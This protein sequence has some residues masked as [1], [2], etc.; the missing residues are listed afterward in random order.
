MGRT[1]VHGHDNAMAL[2]L[3]LF[4]TECFQA[5]KLGH[6]TAAHMPG[7]TCRARAGSWLTN[8]GTRMQVL[9]GGCMW[10]RSQTSPPLILGSRCWKIQGFQFSKVT[11]PRLTGSSLYR[12][13]AELGLPVQA[14]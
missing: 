2:L 7:L 4:R 14:V 1:H 10:S 12:G 13:F 3:T 11:S 6:F 5:H 8:A 9:R